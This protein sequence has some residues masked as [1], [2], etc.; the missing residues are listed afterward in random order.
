MR[1]SYYRDKEAASACGKKSSK[2]GKKH[3][4]T[5]IREKLGIKNIEDL[6]NIVLEN[7]KELVTSPN[8]EHRIIATKEISKYIF[9]T[10][11]EVNATITTHDE[12]VEKYGHLLSK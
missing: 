11:K 9:A 5:I 10:K 12:F 8:I 1:Q 6:K 3:A 4:R 7:W 2:K